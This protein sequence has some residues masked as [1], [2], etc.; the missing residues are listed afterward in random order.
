MVIN[1][2]LESCFMLRWGLRISHL[3]IIS[4]PPFDKTDTLM[5][6]SY[7]MHELLYSVLNTF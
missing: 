5:S 3:S 6:K 4:L 1:K 7:C 2:G